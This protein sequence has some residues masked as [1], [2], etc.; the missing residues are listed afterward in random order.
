MTSLRLQEN[1]VCICCR[2]GGAGRV[3]RGEHAPGARRPARERHQDWRLDG[4]V[5]GAQGQPLSDAHRSRHKDQ[6][7][8]R[9]FL[10]QMLLVQ[11][12]YTSSTH[13]VKSPPGTEVSRAACFESDE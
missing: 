11:V 5:T 12:W 7:R 6:E 2:C 4:A 8:E 13:V 10:L 9:K 3:H 1:V